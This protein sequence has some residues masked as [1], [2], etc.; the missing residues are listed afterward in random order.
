MGERTPDHDQSED[1][2]SGAVASFVRPAGPLTGR[3]VEVSVAFAN[4]CA[5][6]GLDA[7]VSEPQTPDEWGYVDRPLAGMDTHSLVIVDLG[8]RAFTVD[9]T[10]AQ[11]GYP[12]APIIR[13]VE[14][15]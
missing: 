3:C 2:L 10:A 11:Y 7:F 14:K 8:T 12:D 13:E 6:L 4:H 15:S 9:L 1:V 5:A